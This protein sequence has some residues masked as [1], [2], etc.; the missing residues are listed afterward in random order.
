MYQILRIF[1]FLLKVAFCSLRRVQ[2]KI[3]HLCS[4]IL[5]AARQSNIKQRLDVP[6]ADPNYCAEKFATR[7]I[8]VI[9]SQLC[10]GGDFSRDSCDGDS[11]GP[12][13]RYREAWYLEGVVSFGNR[14]GLEGWPG[15]YTRVSEYIDWI[16]GAIRA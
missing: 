7:R 8:N 4:L 11:G 15:V 1:L 5:F 6:V 12:L 9:S 2:I 14:C 16:E 10:A 3:K 13:M